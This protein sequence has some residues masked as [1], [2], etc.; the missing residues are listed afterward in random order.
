[1]LINKSNKTLSL[2]TARG[3][4]N[5]VSCG[6]NSISQDSNLF[7]DQIIGAIENNSSVLP[8]NPGFESHPYKG[9]LDNQEARK[10]I[11]GTFPPISYLI[12]TIRDRDYPLHRLKQPTYPHQVID[13]PQVPFF[14]G[15]VSGLWSVI[16]SDIELSELKR[17]RSLNRNNARTFLINWLLDN[18]IY[19][20]D[21]ILNTQRKL[22]KLKPS[23]NKGYTYEDVNLL[24]ICPDIHLIKKVVTNS[25]LDVICFTN[26][27]TFRTAGLKV[28]NHGIVETKNSDALSIFLRA[29]QNIGFNLEIQCL[30]YFDWTPIRNLTDA[31]KRTKLIFK[32]RIR[33]TNQCTDSLF[34]NFEEKIFSVLTP[35][36]P[37]AHGKIESHPIVLALKNHFGVNNTAPGLLPKIYEMFR[38]NTYTD[39][40]QFNIN[41]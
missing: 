23:D 15:N 4:N 14:H 5:S 20:D 37:A 28:S 2:L 12:D 38:K 33:K 21:I 24:H 25:N 32:L 3:I 31:Q 8:V 7:V 13:E 9:V 41:D 11:I 18:D 27:M 34:D 16:L 22:G 10:Y 17:I 26:G 35:Y 39:L 29:C 40:Y 6:H 36:S 19:Y 30:P 1:M